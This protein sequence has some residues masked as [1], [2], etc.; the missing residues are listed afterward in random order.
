[1]GCAG[2][3]TSQLA[4]VFTCGDYRAEPCNGPTAITR[5]KAK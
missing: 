2:F 1:L 5:T 4:Q 3:Y